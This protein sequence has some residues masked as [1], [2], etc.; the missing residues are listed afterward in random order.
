LPALVAVG[1]ACLCLAAGCSWLSKLAG[2]SAGK[3]RRLVQQARH[4]EEDGDLGRSAEL[5]SR[6]VAANAD[7]PEAHRQLA[8][9]MLARGEDEQAIEH[10]ESAARLN[11]EDAAGW[12]ELAQAHYA[13][14]DYVRA[15]LPLRKALEIDPH[16]TAALLLK[17]ALEEA[18]GDK[19]AALGTYHRLR[20]VDAANVAAMLRI[21]ALQLEFGNPQRAAPMLRSIC[22]CGHASAEQAAEAEWLLGR[23]YGQDGRWA[24]AA[25]ALAVAMRRRA[26]I[27][28]DDWFRLADAYFRAGDPDRARG[29]VTAALELDPQYPP[30]LTLAAALQPAD[31]FRAGSLPLSAR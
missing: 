9:M 1:A 10:L 28:A 20:G 5:L 16:H 22:Q 31:D 4:A 18:R 8:R 19:E 26:P 15:E 23:A 21:A 29:A 12:W 14:K 17:G 7:D 2:D 27:T 13:R 30:A 6:A 3:S 25:A 24:D 11:P